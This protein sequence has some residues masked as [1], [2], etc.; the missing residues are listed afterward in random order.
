MTINGWIQIAIFSLIIMALTK[1]IGGYMTRVF[2]GDRTFLSAVL[3]PFE[4]LI[5]AIC[6]VRED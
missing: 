6:G 1:P 5:Y 4:R 2:N 3:R